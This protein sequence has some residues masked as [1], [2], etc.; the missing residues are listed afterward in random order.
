MVSRT[1][2]NASNPPGHGRA[3]H[4]PA[5][6][7]VNALPKRLSSPILLRLG[8]CIVWRE[9]APKRVGLGR[10][11]GEHPLKG[12]VAFGL[13]EGDELVAKDL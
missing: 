9:D 4:V 1:K 2:D 3:L 6:S 11:H 12:R 10:S 8:R 7:S 5:E 13:L